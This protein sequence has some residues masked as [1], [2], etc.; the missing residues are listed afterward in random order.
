MAAWRMDGKETLLL[1]SI[2]LPEVIPLS[3]HSK[4]AFPHLKGDPVLPFST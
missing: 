2:L 3:A 1:Q 4:A